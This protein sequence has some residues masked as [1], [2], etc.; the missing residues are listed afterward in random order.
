MLAMLG[1]GFEFGVELTYPVGES[2]SSG[3]LMAITNLLGIIIV[4]LDFKLI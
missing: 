4:L 3:I 2:M 1:V